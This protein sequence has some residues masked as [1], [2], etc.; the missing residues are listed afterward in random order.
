MTEHEF[1]EFNILFNEIQM[2][3]D[4][5]TH[6][7]SGGVSLRSWTPLSAAHRMMELAKYNDT[8][9]VEGTQTVAPIHPQRDGVAEDCS[10]LDGHAASAKSSG[11]RASVGGAGRDSTG[12]EA[13]SGAGR[14]VRPT[15]DEIVAANNGLIEAIKNM[16]RAA[17]VESDLRCW[18]CGHEFLPFEDIHT[19]TNGED[20]CEDCC[21]DPECRVE[22]IHA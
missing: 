8:G 1:E 9:A 14:A 12:A 3:L 19:A 13:G 18:E 20:V 11:M 4:A 21:D 22:V 17:G 16:A 6:T 10:F 7:R 15:A 2:T 5:D